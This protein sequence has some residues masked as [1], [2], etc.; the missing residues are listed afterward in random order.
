MVN[1]TFVLTKKNAPAVFEHVMDA[2]KVQTC[3][4]DGDI[5]LKSVAKR[6]TMR[7]FV[8]CIF[9]RFT[10]KL[11]AAKCSVKDSCRKSLGAEG[12]GGT[13]NHPKRLVLMSPI[14]SKAPQD[15]LAAG[16]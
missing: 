1:N 8:E 13:G 14:V 5:G 4:G 2:P 6:M 11:L 15:A 7:L 10:A 9:R 3:D 12:C 16:L